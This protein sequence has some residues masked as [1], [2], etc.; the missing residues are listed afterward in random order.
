MC[1]QNAA[2]DIPIETSSM[3]VIPNS[4]S[5]SLK[6]QYIKEHTYL[7]VQTSVLFGTCSNIRNF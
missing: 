1:K 2:Q 6:R 5:Q 4:P 7:K 3:G